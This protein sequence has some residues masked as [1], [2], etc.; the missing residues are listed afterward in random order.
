MKPGH[1][2]I[3]AIITTAI[4]LF[5][6]YEL[7]RSNPKPEMAPTCPAVSETTRQKF[8]NINDVDI[9]EYFRLKTMEEKYKKADEI[10]GKILTIF[11]ADLGLHTSQ[12]TAKRI[13][14]LSSIPLK[15]AAQ[16]APIGSPIQEP[17][18][19]AKIQ[20]QKLLEAEQ[21]LKGNLSDPD[22]DS[23]LSSVRLDDITPEVHNSAPYS[24]N[25]PPTS[26][27]LSGQYQGQAILQD[28]SHRIWEINMEVSGKTENDY[29][30]GTEKITISENGKIFSDQNG[31]GDLNGFRRSIGG[32]QAI[33]VQASPTIYFQL[34]YLGNLDKFVGN[35][36]Q[37]AAPGIEQYTFKGNISLQKAS[38]G[39]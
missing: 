13:G 38:P 36:Y 37:K 22:I 16:P 35:L 25:Y 39:T 11:L 24:Y 1:T 29:F 21:K 31:N 27:L 30:E 19:P 14:A 6:G 32:S 33:L 8:Q 28:G 20:H 2:I 26:A 15:P 4:G 10:L 3:L 23:F 5:I 34:Y 18:S 17:K 9:A 7:G 12:G